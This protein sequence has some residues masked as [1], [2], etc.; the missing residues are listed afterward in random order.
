MNPSRITRSMRLFISIYL[1]SSSAASRGDPGCPSCPGRCSYE[2]V[3]FDTRQTLITRKR[4]LGTTKAEFRDLT[5]ESPANRHPLPKLIW[6]MRISALLT[7][8]NLLNL[9]TGKI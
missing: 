6:N 3:R 5:P 2:L 1:C 7:A 4:S 8:R 9:T